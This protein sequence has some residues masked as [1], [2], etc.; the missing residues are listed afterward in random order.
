MRDFTIDSLPGLDESVFSALEFY[1]KNPPPALAYPKLRR[2]L[3]VGSGN[4]GITGRI[5]FSKKDAAIA[6]ES[7]YREAYERSTGIDGVVIV[8]ASGGKSSVK[9]AEFFADRQL[10]IY[11]FTATANSQSSKYAPK[12]TVVFPK[13][14]EPY[15]YN[16]STYLGMI[17]AASGENPAVIER[18]I[19]TVLEP[20]IP[21]N[22]SDFNAFFFVIP[23][24]FELIRGMILA[25]FDEL[26][27]SM[28]VGRAFTP[29]QV[30]HSKTV[31]ANPKELFI[32]LG[33]EVETFGPESQR[34]IVPLP[35]P[36]GYA[37]M[38]ATAY[39]V[40]GRIQAAHPQYFKENIAA[41]MKRS[42]NH[43]GYEMSP[44]VE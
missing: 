35:D 43:F 36:V 30:W 29:E 6:T 27:G 40:I 3:V 11:L 38:I 19:T 31:I 33:D 32:H 15:T 17:L 4:A 5:L 7:T 21:K 8:S 18:H 16:V 9:I 44:I 25:K 10:P 12:S 41:Y 42:S 2:P 22:L 23:P 24:R 39:F 28:L 26:F 20:A 37:G 1:K 34:I 14:K 13:I